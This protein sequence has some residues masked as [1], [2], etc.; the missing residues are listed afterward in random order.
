LRTN[1]DR[2]LQ[3]CATLFN[4]SQSRIV[5]SCAVDDAEKILSV[6]RAKNIPH[7]LLGRVTTKMLRIRMAGAEL[8]WA[9]DDL[10]DD[11]FHAIRRAVETDSEPVPSL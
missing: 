1:E 3:T 6:L 7:S 4:E 9:I 8:S 10:Y 2:K 11:W 5:I